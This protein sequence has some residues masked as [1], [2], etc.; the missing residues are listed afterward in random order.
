MIR[1]FIISLI[2]ILMSSL[3]I[4]GLAQKSKADKFFD[5]KDWMNVGVYYYPE[6]WPKEQWE[7]DLKQMAEMGFEFTHFAEFAW[8]FMEPE[9]GKYDFEWL[10]EAVALAAKYK[11]KVIMCTPT[12]TPP[13]WMAEKY[14]E[15]LMVDN[16]GRIMQ[17]GGR[18]HIS[19]SSEKYREFCTKIISE[20]A[21]RY[22]KDKR[23]WGWQLDNEPSHYGAEYDY[24]PAARARFIAWLRNKYGTIERLNRDWG[25]AFWSLQYQS[26]EQVRLPNSR[27]QVQQVN[28]HAL[29]DFKRFTAEECADFLTMQQDILRKYISSDQWVTTNF[30]GSHTPND[31]TLSQNLDFVSYTT[32]PVAGYGYGVGEYGFRASEPIT[33]SFLNDYFRSITG[34]TGVMELQPGQ[35]NWGRYNP[36]VMPGAVRLW[37]WHAFAGGCRFACAYRFRQPLSGGEMYH[38]GMIG[39]DGITPSSGGKEYMQMINE[40]KT[41]RKSWE[42]KS[43]RPSKKAK[44]PKPLAL[45]ISKDNQWEMDYQRQTDQWNYKMHY[46]KYYKL[47]KRMGHGIDFPTEKSDW[48]A[49]PILVAPAYEQVDDALI[50]KMKKYAENGG[51]LILTCRSGQKDKRGHLWEAPYQKPVA[52]LIGA[53]IDF[54]DMLPADLWGKVEIDGKKYE[55]NNWADVLTAHAGTDVWAKYIDH[56]Y[57]G[58]ASVVHKKIGKGTVTYVGV[59]T[60]SGQLEKEVLRKILKMSNLQNMDLPEGVT[61]EYRNGLW[62]ALN[63]HTTEDQV[64]PVHEN[65]KILL[66]EKRLTP[67]GVCIWTEQ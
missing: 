67:M 26:F 45:L 54:F 30:M 19:W 24:S 46:L 8:A 1:C 64:A 55:W 35:V 60:D 42:N 16:N 4:N 62:V 44:E 58:K 20:M 65:A 41:L 56:F 43:N 50:A 2:F 40:L 37:L 51:H 13:V 23:I 25:A 59:D 66:G 52:D 61:V 34:V 14:P 18:Q 6:Q 49:Y 48:S 39:P 17:H 33:I 11:L 53:S 5:T 9:E 63:Y 57:V 27:E 36:Q 12:P 10:D 38:Y 47:L 15:I 31:P 22:G 32:Y 21:K 28:P 29:L 7:R 3:M